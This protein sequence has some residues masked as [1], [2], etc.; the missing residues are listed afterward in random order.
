MRAGLER[1]CHEVIALFG[2]A[3]VAG[4]IAGISPCVLPVLPVLLAAGATEAGEQRSLRRPLAVIAGLIVSFTALTLVGAE[5]L[6]LLHLPLDLLRNI[7]LVLLGLVGF[8][9]IVP[10]FGQLIAR[11]FE[12]IRIP[13]LSKETS[14]FLI[15]LGLGAVFAPCAGP[16]LTAI[17]VVA[18]AHRIGLESVVVTILFSCGA[19]IP[20]FIVALAGTEIVA[21]T[22]ALRRHATVLRAGGGAVLIAMTVLLATNALDGLQTSVPG[23]TTALQSHIEGSAS[24]SRQLTA[25]KSDGQPKSTTA[26]ATIC[27]PGDSKLESCGPAA[28]F[29]G[30]VQWFN[31]PHDEPVTLAELRHKVVLVD[32]WTYSCINCQRALPHVEAWYSRY[33]SGGFEVIGVHTPE[34]AFEHVPSNVRAAAAQ[35]GVHY[36]IA[37]D[38]NYGTWLA[39]G[40]EGWPSD[41]LIDG[42]GIIRDYSS[43]EGDYSQTETLIRQL[44]RANDPKMRLP[45]RTDVPNLTPTEAMTAETYLGYE[46]VAGLD[47]AIVRDAPSTY[48]FPA[49]LP[50]GYFEIGGVWTIHAEEMTSGSGARLDYPVSAKDVYLVLAGSGSVTV[51]VDGSAT[52]TINVSGV[53]RLYTLVS[54]P[55]EFSATVALTFT[56]GVQAYDLTF[57]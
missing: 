21:R 13:R 33:R 7:G 46:R 15:G 31:T 19:A 45:P 24:I 25:L 28:Q 54:R 44:L 18:S 43:G 40:N 11:P 50:I 27:V 17:T 52:K 51:S 5:L 8:G 12:R 49:S 6:T 57:G 32:F 26:G 2:I 36:P 55:K 16:V 47:A 3:I 1:R 34:F 23:Y 29:T 41:Y 9:L 42:N 53:P 37:L 22:Q 35:L 4:V 30:I 14:G 10:V 39:Y 48:A 56:S 38:N 20:L